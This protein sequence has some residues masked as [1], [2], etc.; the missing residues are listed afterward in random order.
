MSRLNNNMVVVTK[1]EGSQCGDGAIS[2]IR[3]MPIVVD[4]IP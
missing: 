1:I 3:G 2:F 4:Y